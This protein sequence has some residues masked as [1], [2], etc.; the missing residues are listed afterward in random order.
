METSAAPPQHQL[1]MGLVPYF[2][3]KHHLNQNSHCTPPDP[4]CSPYPTSPCSRPGEKT[5]W[6]IHGAI[7]HSI[8]SSRMPS[9]GNTFQTRR[10]ECDGKGEE[11]WKNDGGGGRG[12]KRLGDA[13]RE[14]EGEGALERNWLSGDTWDW[15]GQGMRNWEIEVTVFFSFA[16][17]RKQWPLGRA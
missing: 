12:G 16:H 11:Q 13:E 7:H 3:P 8:L 17:Q 6:I 15:W 4:C 10:L 9:S 1:S 2:P 5:K 14:K